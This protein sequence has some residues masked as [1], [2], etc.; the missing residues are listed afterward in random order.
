M[1][2][3]PLKKFR[4]LREKTIWVETFIEAKTQKQAEK[5]LDNSDFIGG[6]HKLKWTECKSENNVCGSETD[7]L[8]CNGE[9]IRFSD[10][11]VFST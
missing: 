9:T 5:R 1:N 2:K 4:V 8:F 3:T 11:P 6:K 10:E 7:T